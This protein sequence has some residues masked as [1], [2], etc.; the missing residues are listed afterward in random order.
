MDINMHTIKLD[1]VTV[2]IFSH[3]GLLVGLGSGPPS[4]QDPL[5]LGSGCIT[6]SLFW[7][8]LVDVNSLYIS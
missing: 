2:T 7:V 1:L 4:F 8:S 6:L 3:S 5:G